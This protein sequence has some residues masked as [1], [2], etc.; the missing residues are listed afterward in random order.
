MGGSTKK[1]VFTVLPSGMSAVF[2]F[3]L[4]LDT[5]PNDSHY[6][7][8]KVLNPTVEL[9]VVPDC[10]VCQAVREFFEQHGLKLHVRQGNVQTMKAPGKKSLGRSS[11]YP[12]AQYQW[13]GEIYTVP[14]PKLHDGAAPATI[15]RRMRDLFV[16]RVKALREHQKDLHRAFEKRSMRV[17][18]TPAFTVFWEMGSGKTLGATSLMVNH[19]SARNVIV[20]NNTNIGYWVEHLRMTPF[21]TREEVAAAMAAKRTKASA[22]EDEA[23]DND[24]MSQFAASERDVVLW[25]EV[26]GYT[27]LRSD[28]DD[29]KALRNYS[30]V[31]LDEAHYFRN[32]TQGMQSA[33]SAIHGAK[34]VIMLSGTPLVNSAEDI[35]GMLALADMDR[36]RDWE[37]EFARTGRLPTPQ[38]VTAMLSGHVSWFD[39]R[40]HRP[41]MFAK[42]YPTLEDHLERVPMTYPQTIEY[43][44]A[45]RSNFTFGP[46]TV[47]QGR[48]NRYNCLTRAVCNAPDG[49]PASSPKLWRVLE[50]MR[51]IH[52]SPESGPQLAHSSQVERGIRPLFELC[53]REHLTDVR[54][55][56][57]I[58]GATDNT[59][60]ECTRKLYNKGKLDGL[61]IS[62]ASQFGMDLVATRAVHLVEPHQNKQS[63]NQTTARALRMGSHNNCAYKVVLRYKYISVFPPQPPT[64]DEVDACR[65]Y[66]IDQQVLGSDTANLL[67]GLDIKSLIVKKIK[68]EGGKTINETQEE[69]NARK[70]IGI[71]PYLEAYR[72]ATVYMSTQKGAKLFET[73]APVAA[74]ADVDADV[75]KA[76][77][78]KVKKD[79]AGGK[80]ASRGKEGDEHNAGEKGKKGATDSKGKKAK[81]EAVT[82]TSS[83]KT[84]KTKANISCKK[85]EKTEKAGGGSAKA[86]I[87][88]KKAQNSSSTKVNKAEKAEKTEKAEKAEKAEKS[89]KAEKAEKA[90]ISKKAEICKKAENGKKAEKAESGKKAEIGK[91]AEIVKKAEKAE[92]GKKSVIGKKTESKGSSRKGETDK[93]ADKGV[94]AEIKESNKK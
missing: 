1:A 87:S 30:C 55:M 36:T 71:D 60:R 40:V 42:F 78:V 27:A 64:P 62:D 22:P 20:C 25:F 65:K 54:R 24:V 28:F 44:M 79:G 15:Q 31:V 61:F 63:E 14:L 73:I 49:N 19:R 46:Y 74:D 16:R 69:D 35:V 13:N 85:P 57:I 37:G 68:E 47:Q 93:K 10:V 29:P 6:K 23:S 81:S 8:I 53:A 72:R 3:T 94:K 52:S 83:K 82:G 56:G 4:L 59:E 9:W 11:E 92:S 84:D 17:R 2:D 43:L 90:E 21:I 34:N 88:S 67:A 66:M 77:A 80:K 12:I 91:N 75:S 86:N 39:P 32:N 18:N 89:E 7:L 50:R 45:V 48:S 76:K 51:E 41:N 38:D 70:Q 26:V 33:V 58:T 5:G